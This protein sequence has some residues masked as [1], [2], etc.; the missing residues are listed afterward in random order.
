LNPASIGLLK[1]YLSKETYLN[2]E[3]LA[4]SIKKL[5]IEIIDSALL[6]EAISTTGEIKLNALNE[7]FQMIMMKN[8]YCIGEMLDLDAPTGGYLLQSC[9][10]MGILLARHLNAIP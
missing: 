7:N 3:L 8:H 5:P 4:Q 2:P 10:S 6:D 1:I 9:F